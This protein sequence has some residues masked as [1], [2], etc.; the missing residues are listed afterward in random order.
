MKLEGITLTLVSTLVALD[1]KEYD[2]VHAG[3]IF[4]FSTHNS[5][6]LIVNRDNYWS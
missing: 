6:I 4:V 2:V 3:V 5:N 1:I